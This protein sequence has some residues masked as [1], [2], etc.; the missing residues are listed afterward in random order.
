MIF[1][2]L[3]AI[4]PFGAILLSGLAALPASAEPP[5]TPVS[6][7]LL[8]NITYA[9]VGDLELKLDLAKPVKA[10][11]LSPCIVVIHG[12]A[13]RE[14]DKRAHLGDIRAFAEQGYVAATI[15]YRFCPQHRFPAQIE[16]AQAAVR[17]L[18]D[19]ANEHHI[20]VD[21]I[22][23]MGFSAGAHLAML[24]GV[25]DDATCKVQAVVSY[26]GPTDLAGDNMPMISAP[27]V[28]EFIGGTFAEKPEVY[29]EASPITYVDSSD[30]PI[31][32]FQGTNDVLVPFDQA[33][34]M[35]ET[36]SKQQVDGRLELLIGEGHGWRGKDREHTNRQSVEFFDLHLKGN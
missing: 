18:R 1:R 24:L 20:D 17:F 29:R 25:M 32:L 15:Q 30:A 6:I 2:L 10:D 8:E 21:R 9:T 19:H 14:G 16:D 33:V 35:A 7:E 11:K 22:G 27:L 28:A 5:L 13:W 12:G 36:M 26:F 34:R 31:L 4:A 23:A 3:I